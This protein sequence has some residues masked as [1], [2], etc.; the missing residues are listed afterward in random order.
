MTRKCDCEMGEREGEERGGA[1]RD[2]NRGNKFELDLGFDV[3]GDCGA[4]IG[5]W[6]IEHELIQMR[7]GELV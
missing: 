3:S 4:V 7:F 6:G 1:A 2:C 5:W